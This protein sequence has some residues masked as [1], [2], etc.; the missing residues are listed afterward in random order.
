MAGIPAEEFVV[1]QGSEQIKR[2]MKSENTVLAFCSV[3][4]SS[5]FAEKPKRGM[6]HL[7]IGTLNEA[8]SLRP[9]FHSYVGSKAEWDTICDGLPQFEEG[10]S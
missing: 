7:R 6:V 1:V 2:Y 9:Q 3:C 5:L 10:R 8:P 4:G